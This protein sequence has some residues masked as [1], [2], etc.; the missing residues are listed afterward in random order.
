MAPCRAT[1]LAG[2]AS[3][4]ELQ[5]S[6]DDGSRPAPTELAALGHLI[7]GLGTAVFRVLYRSGAQRCHLHWP[8]F[9]EAQR[10]VT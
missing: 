5:P 2:I 1:R 4:N 7:D 3:I 10:Q 9:P 8:F 6:S